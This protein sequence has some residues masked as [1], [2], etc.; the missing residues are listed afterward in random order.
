LAHKTR[1][2]AIIAENPL[3]FSHQ[4]LSLQRQGGWGVLILNV[5]GV[6]MRTVKLHHILCFA[7]VCT[8]MALP[9]AWGSATRPNIIVLLCDDLGYGDLSCFGHPVIKTPNLDRLAGEGLRLTACYS[10][11]PVCSPSRVGL[12]TGRSPNRAGVYDWI[13]PGGRPQSNLRDLVHMQKDE[14]TLPMILSRAGYQTC[15]V[16][17]WHCN[18]R[19]NSPAQPQPDQAGFDHWF[20]TQNNAAPSHKNPK[21]FVRNGEPVGPLTGFSAGLIVEEAIQWL[22]RRDAQHPFYLQVCFHEP[23]EPVASPA[24]LV[25]TYRP[26]A[27][28][29]DQAQ[30]FANVA[31]VD[32]AVGRLLGFLSSRDLRDNTL[33]VFT[34]D[35]GPETL[36]RYGG[37]NRS[38]GSPGALKGMKLWTSEAGF[39]VPGIVNWPGMIKPGGVSDEVVSSLDLLP[40]FCALAGGSLPQHTLD[41]TDLSGFLKGQALSRTRPLL[42]CYYNSLNEHAVAMRTGD[43]KILA[44]IQA[45]GKRLPKITNVHAGNQK[46][47]QDAV[48]GNFELYR[49]KTDLSETRDVAR[50]FP[51]K[52]AELSQQLQREYRAL[53]Q[54]S[55]VW[56]R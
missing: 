52:F 42:W 55:H 5:L 2:P 1:L 21:N 16:G 49:V 24:E 10:A 38:Y 44:T 3:T 53:V 17:K 14:I 43:W 40:T 29:E 20:S 18:S 47:I 4:S 31:N 32:Q 35:N 6:I 33:I 15:L 23:H 13:P 50:V 28:N 34:S 9:P 56:T 51:E 25:N 46:T 19:F 30:Y 36:K 45:H 12:L 41:G 54:G 39:R 27:A 48:L 8:A 11:A 22:G 26:K 37:A 7:I